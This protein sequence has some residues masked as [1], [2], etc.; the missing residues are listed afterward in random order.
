MPTQSWKFT[1]AK[2]SN[3][4]GITSDEGSGVAGK[5]EWMCL[6]AKLNKKSIYAK[7]RRKQAA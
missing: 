7:N 6:D 1:S 2:L 3:G 5:L 4:A